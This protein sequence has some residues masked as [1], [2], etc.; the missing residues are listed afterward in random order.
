MKNNRFDWILLGKGKCLGSK[1]QCMGVTVYKDRLTNCMFV[2]CDP[3]NCII[4]R[5]N[6]TEVVKIFVNNNL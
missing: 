2:N 5:L 1:L 3:S 4:V 6:V